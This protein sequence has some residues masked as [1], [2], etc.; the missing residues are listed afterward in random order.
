MVTDMVFLSSL[1]IQNV[2][3]HNEKFYTFK[4]S[5]RLKLMYIPCKTSGTSLF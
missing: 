1:H 4:S 3:T 5:C 2:S